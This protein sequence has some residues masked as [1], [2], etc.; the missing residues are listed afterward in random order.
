MYRLRSAGGR[1]DEVARRLPGPPPGRCYPLAAL[2]P[3]VSAGL[4]RTT[5]RATTYGVVTATVVTTA[6]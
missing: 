2:V 1:P 5:G 6:L 4:P 3:G